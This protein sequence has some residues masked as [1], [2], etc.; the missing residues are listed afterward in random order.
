MKLTISVAT[1]F[2]TLFTSAF[3]V[4]SD[5][6]YLVLHSDDSKLNKHTLGAC[7]EGAGIEGLCKASKIP[8]ADPDYQTYQLNYTRGQPNV[9][10][11]TWDL[12]G[13]NVV[14]KYR[15]C[16]SPSR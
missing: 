11:V 4:Q 12:I 3:A 7:H 8:K 5:D 16:N 13:G 9:G 14:G 1:L 6:F 15:D 10:E 2:I